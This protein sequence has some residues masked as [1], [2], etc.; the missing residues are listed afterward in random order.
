MD[1][2]GRGESRF[3]AHIVYVTAQKRK[4]S[5]LNCLISGQVGEPV[6]IKNLVIFQI[7]FHLEF[8]YWTM[9]SQFIIVILRRT[10]PSMSIVQTKNIVFEIL[11]RIAGLS[12]IFIERRSGLVWIDINPNNTITHGYMHIVIVGIH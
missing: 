5:E 7:F 8:I 9:R 3:C 12:L 11:I 1:V 4:I 10:T 2:E 6:Q